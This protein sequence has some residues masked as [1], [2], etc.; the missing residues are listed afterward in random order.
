M[1]V[2]GDNENVT[3][4]FTVREIKATDKILLV[5]LLL[6][7][8]LSL[9]LLLLSSSSSSL[10]SLLLFC[11]HQTQKPIGCIVLRKSF[12]KWF[13]Y[14]TFQKRNNSEGFLIFTFCEDQN[15]R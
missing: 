13:K 14:V 8:L 2:A 10:L 15:Y 6:L 5:L 1:R 9:L 7:L 4:V 3:E 12:D 11:I